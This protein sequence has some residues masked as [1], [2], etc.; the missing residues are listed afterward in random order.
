MLKEFVHAGITQS[1]NLTKL[2][3]CEST[4]VAWAAFELAPEISSGLGGGHREPLRLGGGRYC[5]AT[6]PPSIFTR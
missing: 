6:F 4:R 5:F 1:C 2:F 3:G